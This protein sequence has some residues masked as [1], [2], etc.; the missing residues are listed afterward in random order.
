MPQI[1]A[2]SIKDPHATNILKG[3]K[4]KE[5][6]KWQT[7]YRGPLLVCCAASP[8]TDN[9]GKALCIVNLSDIK[10]FGTFYEWVLTDLQP[11]KPIPIK[12]SLGLFSATI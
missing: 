10:K 5:Y 6:R 4:T 1:K 9:A 3:K 2:I 7:P 12:G 8:K 11:I